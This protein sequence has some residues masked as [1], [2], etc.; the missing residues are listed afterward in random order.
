LFA[1][2]VII[3]IAIVADIIVGS[4]GVVDQQKKAR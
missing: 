4:R 2:A 1:V 3:V